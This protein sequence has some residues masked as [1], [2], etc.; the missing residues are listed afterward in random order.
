MST[1]SSR[2]GSGVVVFYPFGGSN[3][4]WVVSLLVDKVVL[5]M[6]EASDFMPAVWQK[7]G[8]YRS[9]KWKGIMFF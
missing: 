1:R 7:R 8:L 3:T 5:V 2:N 6:L 4:F 9:I